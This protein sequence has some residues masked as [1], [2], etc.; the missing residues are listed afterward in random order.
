LRKGD[1][2]LKT[3]NFTVLIDG[4]A[5]DEGI[6]EQYDNIWSAITSSTLVPLV[7]RDDE[8]PHYVLLYLSG[9]ETQTGEEFKGQMS[10][11][12]VEV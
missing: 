7:F 10:L 1:A 4:E 12:A 2:N 8:T 9:S 11:H 6:K 3:W 5:S